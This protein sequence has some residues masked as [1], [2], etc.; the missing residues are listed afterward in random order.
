MKKL[1]L[2]SISMLWFVLPAFSQ[3]QLTQYFQD[4]TLYNPAFAGSQEAVCASMFGRKQWMGF[5]DVYGNKVAPQSFVFNL[6]APLYDVH[7]GIGLNVVYD[8]AG[9]ET[10]LGAKINYNYRH[11]FDDESKSLAIGVGG[12]IL[13]KSIDFS[14][15]VPEEPGDPLLNY[16]QEESGIIPDVDFGIHYQQR[17]KL[18]L[19]LSATN[20]LE[21]SAEIGNVRYG[22]KRN[23]Y[24][25]AGYY[26]TLMETRNNLLTLIP[27]FQV[28]SNLANAQVDVNARV[29]YNHRFWAGVSW[30]YQ[31]AIALMAGINVKGFRIGASYDYT[32]GKLAEV[33]NGSAEIFVGYCI[34][35]IP[36][37]KLKSLYNT[38]YL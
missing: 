18:Y 37:V 11:Y 7:S 33:S 34:P 20:L 2:I 9:F 12:S 38:R 15:L 30:R 23:L 13:N 16:K 19:G 35:V 28:E 21:S 17:D 29:E 26:I 8:R 31:D 5:E 22:Q 1:L 24:A 6:H 3:V 27:S 14:K 32:T 10:N 36:N 25:T 4:G